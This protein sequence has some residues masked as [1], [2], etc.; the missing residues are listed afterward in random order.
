[1]PRSKC[2]QYNDEQ[3]R[4]LLCIAK[5]GPLSQKEI[6]RITGIDKRNLSAVTDE[7]SSH[8]VIKLLELPKT[9]GKR[10]GR[11]M[12]YFTLNSPWMV[13]SICDELK[14][15]KN[16]YEIEKK[17]LN[18]R[19]GLQS[20]AEWYEISDNADEERRNAFLDKYTKLLVD[21]I[22][23]GGDDGSISAKA[24]ISEVEG[25]PTIIWNYYDAI[26]HSLRYISHQG[27]LFWLNL[28]QEP[29]LKVLHFLMDN[30]TTIYSKSEIAG[31]AALYEDD[32]LKI[33]PRLKTSQLIIAIQGS[34]EETYKLNIQNRGVERLMDKI[35]FRKIAIRKAL[36][37]TYPD[38]AQLP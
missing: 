7:L 31:G 9:M 37:R 26:P 36:A 35:G 27:V 20:W 23:L 2:L 5:F 6:S 11:P 1:M 21:R 17:E 32:L 30:P 24:V 15:R 3:L 34:L 25:K 16:Q 28:L 13:Q 33:L 18:S 29:S 10:R 38:P 8:K 14:Y 12:Q 4:V 22:N 19:I